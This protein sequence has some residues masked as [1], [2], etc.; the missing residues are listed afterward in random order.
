MAPIRF[1]SIRLSYGRHDRSLTFPDGPEPYVIVGQNGSGKTTL[2]E[3]LI[4]AIFGFNR[5][6]GDGDH[7]AARLPWNGCKCDAAVRLIDRGGDEIEFARC[8]DDDEVIVTD[9]G[10]GKVLFQGEAN[11]AGRNQATEHYGAIVWDR[12]GIRE[13]STYART[14]FIAQGG[15]PSSQIGADLLQLAV[16]GA[17]TVD[18][19]KSEIE[20]QVKKLTRTGLDGAGRGRK[21][22]ELEAVETQIAHLQKI[23]GDSERAEGARV[24]LQNALDTTLAERES[25]SRRVEQLMRAQEPVATHQ[26]GVERTARLEE[27]L[28]SVQAEIAALGELGHEYRHAAAE[29]ER[30]RTSRLYPSDFRERCAVLRQLWAEQEREQAAA[31]DARKAG[32]SRGPSSRSLAIGSAAMTICAV[33]TLALQYRAIAVSLLIAA[34]VLA[35]VWWTLKRD[36]RA[37]DARARSTLEARAARLTELAKAIAAKLEGVPDPQLLTPDTVAHTLSTFDDQQAIATAYIKAEQRL[38]DRVAD[39]SKRMSVLLGNLSSPSAPTAGEQAEQLLQAL[40]DVQYDTM[41]KVAAERYALEKQ[42]DLQSQLPAGIA[43]NTRAIAGALE[44]SRKE[45]V[46]LQ[47]T[48]VRLRQRLLEEGTAG[49]SALALA[50]RLERLREQR[51]EIIRRITV[52]RGAAVLLDDAYARFRERDQARLLEHVSTRACTLSN[53]KLGPFST[54]STL[55]EAEIRAYNRQLAIACPPLSFGEMHCAGLAIRLGCADFL[56]GINIVLPLLIDDPFAHLDGPHAEAVWALLS[57]IAAERQVIV[58]THETH[59]LGRLGIKSQV[60]FE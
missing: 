34:F 60:C 46:A 52:L 47:Q 40:R 50:D 3:C 11:P 33:V 19:A 51:Q 20:E 25:V 12:I 6:G 27:Q 55:E 23:M 15:L 14:L 41:Q 57:K 1:R 22:R 28:K 42:Q 4:R 48:I 16:G 53:G 31:A 35:A 2:L 58:T 17:G 9:I 5:R 29:L 21:E 13:L 7:L 44:A 30:I 36:E 8:F 45:E 37:A 49:E 39:V 10:R 59:F 32:D 24:P 26:A 38:R 18:A 56:A 54:E 43:L